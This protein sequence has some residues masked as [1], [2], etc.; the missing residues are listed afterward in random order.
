MRLGA[1]CEGILG[2]VFPLLRVV[3]FLISAKKDAVC[4]IIDSKKD[5]DSKLL[6]SWTER[7]PNMTHSEAQCLYRVELGFEQPGYLW[8]QT[9]ETP[10]LA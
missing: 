6:I 5:N 10:F 4:I 7:P 9:P 3:F 2:T 8:V 1:K